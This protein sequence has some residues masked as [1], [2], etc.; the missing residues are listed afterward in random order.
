MIEV[1]LQNL[2]NTGWG[3]LLFIGAYASNMCF[4][5]WYNIKMLNQ[6]FEKEKLINSGIKIAVFGIGTTLLVMVVT[7]LPLFAD[8]VGFAIPTEYEEIFSN[9]VIV[10]VFLTATC[11]YAL[12][13]Y[14]KMKLVLFSDKT[15]NEENAS[16]T[17]E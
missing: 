10:A 11:K 8:R 7:T 5:L 4:S 1:I 6:E 17:I 3:V 14:N 12:E 15:A 16:I 2:I 9:L 13:A